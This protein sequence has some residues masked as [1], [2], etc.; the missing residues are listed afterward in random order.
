MKKPAAVA[1]AIVAVCAL[2]WGARPSLPDD[3]PIFLSSHAEIDSILILGTS[4]SSPRY[5]WP[6]KLAAALSTCF[7]HPVEMQRITQAGAGSTWATGEIKNVITNAP[8]VILIELAINDADI[9]DGISLSNSRSNHQD[10]LSR[11]RVSLPDAQIL[12]MTTSPVQGLQQI[13]RYRLGAFFRLYSSLSERYSTGL[14]HLH[15]QWHGRDLPDGLH[16]QNEDANAVMVPQLSS[17][18][19]GGR[20]TSAG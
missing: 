11:L 7:E 14:I 18:I 16:P 9:V 2:A 13:K 17:I 8:N 12:L 20:C 10:I 4:L 19:S 6:D 1:F 15:S 3:P 5:D